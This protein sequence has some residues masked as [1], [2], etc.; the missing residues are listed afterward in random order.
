MKRRILLVTAAALSL[1]AAASGAQAL[2]VST[3]ASTSYWGCAGVRAIDQSLCVKN[4]L[5]EQLPKAPSV[6]STPPAPT[7]A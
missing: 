5:P 7:P 6:P 3:P 2:S 4:P 1:S